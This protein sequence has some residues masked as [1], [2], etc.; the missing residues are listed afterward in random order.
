MNLGVRRRA[1]QLQP[2]PSIRIN[3]RASYER[4]R[5]LTSGELERLRRREAIFF[6]DVPPEY[7]WLKEW[8]Y[9]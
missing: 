5:D 8:E 2:P 4:M 9:V 1:A 3:V 7:A 6:A